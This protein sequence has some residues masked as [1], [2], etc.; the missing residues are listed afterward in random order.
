[1]H[2][3]QALQNIARL[4]LDTAPLIYFV[5]R[6]PDY[7][8]VVDLI[9]EHFESDITPVVGVATVSECLVGAYRL[10]LTELE[11][12]YM[13]IFA[14]ED[15]LFIESDRHIAQESAKIRAKYNLKLPDALQIATA[16]VKDRSSSIASNCDAFLTN[17]EQLKRV[18]ELNVIVIKDLE[19]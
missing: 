14:R 1:M 5:E 4:F 16:M 7:T 6:N 8:A 2:V 12:T 3:D 10:G 11:K 9:F 15:V 17:D 18:Q 13:G 19:A